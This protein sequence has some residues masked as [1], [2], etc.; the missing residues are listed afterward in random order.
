MGL[1]FI[2]I[3][4]VSFIIFITVIVFIVRIIKFG[5]KVTKNVSQTI[6]EK[7]DPDYVRNKHK[8][9]EQENNDSDQISPRLTQDDMAKGRGFVFC[10]YCGCKNKVTEFRCHSCK[11]PLK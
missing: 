2:F 4:I 3:P 9:K 1:F 8:I 10:Q 6:L 7:T 5:F 11:A